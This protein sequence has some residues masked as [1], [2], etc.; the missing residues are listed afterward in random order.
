MPS[1]SAIK[2][3]HDFPVQGEDKKLLYARHLV[4]TWAKAA[5]DKG[6]KPHAVPG[7]TMR[8]SMSGKCSRAIHYY[9]AGEKVTNPFDLPAY[10]ATGLGTAIHEWWQDTLREAFPTATVEVPCHIPSAD[11]S[12]AADAVVIQEDGTRVLLELKS[13][14]GFGFKRMAEG[15]E[16]PRHGDYVQSAMNAYALNCD[17]LVLIY[18]SLEAI[19]R[20]RAASKGLDEIERIAKEFRVEKQHFMPT[21]EAELK[22]WESI[23]ET[24]PDTPRI[25]PDPEYVPGTVVADPSKGRLEVAG[26]TAGY[27]WQCGYCGY[28]DQCAADA[29]N[30]IGCQ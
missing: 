1:S 14:N 25:I 2:K 8:H 30:G 10:W 4:E 26:K 12:G 20:G 6:P 23:R 16:G 27:A 24:G 11:S 22:R 7:T 19:S 13:I 3:F 28:Q 9:L 15:G 21:V 17:E 18:L 29:A 5:Q